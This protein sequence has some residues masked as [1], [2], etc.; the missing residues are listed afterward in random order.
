MPAAIEEIAIRP[1]GHPKS[2]LSYIRVHADTQTRVSARAAR[3]RDLTHTPWTGWT[4]GRIEHWRGLQP[5]TLRPPSA[6]NRRSTMNQPAQQADRRLLLDARIGP[7]QHAMAALIGQGPVYLC[8]RARR[9]PPRPVK[10]VGS[11]PP[12]LRRPPSP[13]KQDGLVPMLLTVSG[14]IPRVLAARGTQ[15]VRRPP[16]SSRCC[17]A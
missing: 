5:A 3:G 1:P 6:Q 2:R 16:F 11:F 9:V 15:R 12:W 10:S 17:T 8:H 4:G 14:Q 7:S 13:R